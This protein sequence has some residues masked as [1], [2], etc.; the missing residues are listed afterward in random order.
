VNSTA[1]IMTSTK[2]VGNPKPIGGMMYREYN[3]IKTDLKEIGC[4][5]VGWVNVA[6]N[7]V[8]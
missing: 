6:Y 3:N 7:R 8:Q 5:T 2:S 1:A 4:E